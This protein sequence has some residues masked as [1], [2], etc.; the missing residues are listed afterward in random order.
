MILQGRAISSGKVEGCVLKLNGTFSFLGGVNASTGDLNAGGGNIAGKVFVF[1]SGKGSTVGS[2]VMYDLMVHGKSPAAVINSSAETIVTTGAVISSIPMVDNV[3]IDLLLDG[4]DVI[5][6]GD[7][8][9][10]EIR[11]VKIIKVVSSALLN[12]S[13]KVLMLKRPDTVKSFPGR[14][15]LVAGKVESNESLESAASR[16][17][18]EETQI[19]VSKPDACLPPIYV[20]EMDVIWEVYPFLFKVE[21]Q[22]PVLNKENTGYEWIKPDEIKKDQSIVPQTSDVVNKMMK[23]L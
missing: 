5:V 4:D 9:T 22:D 16:E 11:N 13:G 18:M 1:H 17:I 14:K 7:S 15:S 2:F 3:D 12:K 6:D 8:G 19:R 20:R 23:H 21:D 10:V